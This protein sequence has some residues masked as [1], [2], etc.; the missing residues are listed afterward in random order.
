M[1]LV[2]LSEVIKP[3][4]MLDNS[5]LIQRSRIRS[6]LKR[7]LPSHEL[8]RKKDSR[9]DILHNMPESMLSNLET[10][11]KEAT[12]EPEVPEKSVY[13]STAKSSTPQQQPKPRPRAAP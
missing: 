6:F 13:E 12:P 7:K 10:L 8:L 5:A 2:D 11:L 9:G 1:Y 3:H 4:K